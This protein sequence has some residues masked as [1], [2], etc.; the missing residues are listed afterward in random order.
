LTK[1]SVCAYIVFNGTGIT[2]PQKKREHIMAAK[3]FGV[4]FH[5]DTRQAQ[6]LNAQ[7]LMRVNRWRQ[8]H[9]Q[10]ALNAVDGTTSF[11]VYLPADEDV[12]ALAVVVHE[13]SRVGFEN[14]AGPARVRVRDA[15]ENI[16][17]LLGVQS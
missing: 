9:G 16:E 10:V 6:R 14:G 7:L 3:N 12:R 11:E 8:R 1:K 13:L 5:G 2:P 15:E 17:L 4:L